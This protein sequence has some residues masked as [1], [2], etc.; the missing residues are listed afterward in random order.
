MDAL[1]RLALEALY[2]RKAY[3]DSNPDVGMGPSLSTLLD[4]VLQ[5]AN[6]GYADIA[7]E[8]VLHKAKRIR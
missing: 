6:L 4:E 5:E 8:D 7:Y 2:W 3:A 1:S